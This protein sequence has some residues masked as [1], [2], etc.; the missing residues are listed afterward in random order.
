MQAESTGQ[1][2]ARG[3]SPFLGELGLFMLAL[4]SQCHSVTFVTCYCTAYH[5]PRVLKHTSISFMVF[6]GESLG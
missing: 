3:K 4:P 1:S 6:L 5:K 2:G